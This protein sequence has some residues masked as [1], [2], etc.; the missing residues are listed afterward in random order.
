MRNNAKNRT[1]NVKVRSS[2]SLGGKGA[3][4]R[5]KVEIHHNKERADPKFVADTI[6]GVQRVPQR[7]KRR[8]QMER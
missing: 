7:E 4:P 1:V 5:Q 8:E 6:Y 3:P 2:R